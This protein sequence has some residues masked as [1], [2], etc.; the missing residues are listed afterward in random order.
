MFGKQELLNF[1]WKI[2][3]LTI[4]IA[5]I[6]ILTIYSS[7]YLPEFQK[8]TFDPF[9][10]NHFWQRQIL[11]VLIGICAIFLIILFDY[12]TIIKYAYVFYIV[13]ILLLCSL[14]LVGDIRSGSRRWID[15][16]FFS[17]QPSEIAKLSL[18]LT[19]TRFFGESKKRGA[20]SLWELLKP[21]IMTVLPMSLILLQPDLGTSVSIGF[22]FLAMAFAVGLRASSW[23][24]LGTSGILASCI[25]WFFLKDYQKTRLLIFFN[26]ERDPLGSG[27]NIIQS[28]VAIGSGG[29]LGKGFL[30]G[31]Q[32]QLRF[33][34]EHHTD[35]ILSVF[36][37]EWGFVGVAVILIL[38]ACFLLLC[39][40][41][42]Q[43]AK[44][45]I[46]ALLT[47]GITAM[48]GFNVIIN[49]GMSVGLLPVVGI[50]LPL[51]SYGGSS[52]VT[53]MM[54]IGLILNVNMRRYL[55]QKG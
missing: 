28:K 34:P 21:G 17:F 16:A 5:S 8:E 55:F 2:F 32:G 46:A 29:F 7:T 22:L 10:K 40:R 13:S 33:L 23:I 26:P 4:L 12:H 47:F 31:T 11:W 48:L 14:F 36:A 53:N 39:L 43:N 9:F 24:A 44:D 20:Y 52:T 35:F 25:M 15:L 49:I 6:G 54:G 18:I 1:D 51:V 50:P 45:K 27:Y 3:L 41:S 30:K 42:A 38:L 19:L 37:E